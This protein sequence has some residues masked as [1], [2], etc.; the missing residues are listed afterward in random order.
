M[1]CVQSTVTVECF[2]VLSNDFAKHW[3]TYHSWA[4]LRAVWGLKYTHVNSR[5]PENSAEMREA[6]TGA[7]FLH[8]AA[9]LLSFTA[10]AWFTSRGKRYEGMLVNLQSCPL[11]PGNQHAKRAPPRLSRFISSLKGRRGRQHY[12]LNY[13]LLVTSKPA[14]SCLAALPRCL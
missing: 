3:A 6:G 7:A 10:T 12:W 1:P 14:I 2:I 13:A 8:N 4:A 11:S 9:Q 5:V